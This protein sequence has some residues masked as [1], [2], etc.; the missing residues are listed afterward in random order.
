MRSKEFLVE[1]GLTPANLVKHNGLYLTNMLDKI[2][3]GG[4]FSVV[5]KKQ[6]QFGKTVKIDPAEIKNLK[7]I[8]YPKGNPNLVKISASGNIILPEP[9]KNIILKTTS[10]KLISTGALEKTGDIKGKG[11]DYNI[12]DLGEIAIALAVYARFIKQGAEVSINDVIK[13]IN[14]LNIGYSKT[15][16]AGIADVNSRISWPKGKIDQI[17]LNC[18]LP[19]RSIDYIS[20]KIKNTKKISDPIVEAAFFAAT[21]Y[22]N[23]NSK[24][25]TGIIQVRDNLKTN[26]INI[27]CDGV[28]DQ[29]GTKADV[30]MDIDGKPINIV[31]AKVGRSQLGQASGHSFDKQVLFFKT[32][33]GEDV[34]RFSKKWGQ[35]LEDH[36][37][38]LEQIWNKI[39]PKIVNAC[40][41]DNTSKEMPIVKQLA[42]GLI[43]YS[44][45]A[46]AGDVDIVKLIAAPGNPGFKLLRVDEKLYDAL[47]Q[48]DLVA[49]PK[50]TGIAIYGIY[51]GKKILLMRARSYLSKGANTVRT[52]IEGGDLLDILAE[53][54]DE[55]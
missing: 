37:V 47:S 27:T 43:K 40:K 52:I 22:A 29:K 17:S 19:R 26:I 53:V 32:V 7:K 6:D 16:S 31:S 20:E 1:A 23:K 24:V 54:V 39:N 44:N 12:G 36:Y 10:G 35:T 38:V 48:V 34:S 50:S 15:E 33:F 55:K 28:S 13:V 51:N 45:T 4:E 11:A 3:N 14:K 21:M 41:G 8:F 2:V 30:I 18:V 5:G 42:N 9:V 25:D 49:E 46:V